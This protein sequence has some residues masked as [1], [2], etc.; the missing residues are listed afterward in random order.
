MK[1]VKHISTETNYLVEGHIKTIVRVKI[2]GY[3][4]SVIE[5]ISGGKIHK[6]HVT[7]RFSSSNWSPLEVDPITWIKD[8]LECGMELMS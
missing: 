6:N 8:S 2:S 7:F 4:K 1:E 3:P 5:E